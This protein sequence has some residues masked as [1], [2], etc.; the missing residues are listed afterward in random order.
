MDLACV[1]GQT[2]PLF[3]VVHPDLPRPSPCSIPFYFPCNSSLEIMLCLEILYSLL[4]WQW[5]LAVMPV[6]VS[7]V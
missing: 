7:L 6:V 4:D 1:N 5:Q 2:C 3:D